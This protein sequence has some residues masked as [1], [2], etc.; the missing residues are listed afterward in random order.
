MLMVNGGVALSG[1]EAG[2]RRSVMQAGT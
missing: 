2:N 1:S